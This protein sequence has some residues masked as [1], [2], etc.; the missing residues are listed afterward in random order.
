MPHV[1]RAN[2]PQFDVGPKVLL[3]QWLRLQCHNCEG[4]N[5]LP[6]DEDIITMQLSTT[7]ESHMDHNAV[8]C[9]AF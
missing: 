7:V 8:F 2:N 9:Q 1:N 5:V 3:Q 4:V 6:A